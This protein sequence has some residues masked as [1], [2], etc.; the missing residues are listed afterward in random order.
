[1]PRNSPDL[2]AFD[3]VFSSL[4]SGKA[5]SKDVPDGISHEDFVA[6]F[7]KFGA[8]SS[9]IGINYIEET[10]L[11]RPR[12]ISFIP[13]SAASQA[14]AGAAIVG[15]R[16]PTTVVI[17]AADG[18][19][20][21]LHDL[22]PMRLSFRVL[23]WVGDITKSEPKKRAQEQLGPTRSLTCECDE[24]SGTSHPLSTLSGL[25]RI[26]IMASPTVSQVGWQLPESMR[27]F[28][29]NRGWEKVR[30][31]V[32]ETQRG[33]C[34]SHCLVSFRSLPM[35]LPTTVRGSSSKEEKRTSHLALIRTRAQLSSFDPIIMWQ[36]SW[37]WTIPLY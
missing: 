16:I 28:G 14:L 24:G 23:L 17:R 15:C 4:F 30:T 34:V 37:L 32:G 35:T 3:R 25:L 22:L 33:S 12:N 9:G 18:R 20:F 7:R 27:M 31:F 36:P 21:Q 1:M 26:S 11:K 5:Y 2:I 8:F 19:R 10:S 6:A 13:P 29:D